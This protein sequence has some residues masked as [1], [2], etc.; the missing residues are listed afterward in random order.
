MYIRLSKRRHDKKGE[1]E[2]NPKSNV[3]SHYKRKRDFLKNDTQC[4]KR[5][6]GHNNEKYEIRINR[7]RVCLDCGWEFA[8][9]LKDE[10]VVTLATYRREILV[11]IT[12]N[13]NK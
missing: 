10:G 2:F 8:Q 7:N 11:E 3:I 1:T 9:W 6:T 13:M 12:W 4:H 5:F